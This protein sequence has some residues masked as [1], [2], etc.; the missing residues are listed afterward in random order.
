MTRVTGPTTAQSCWASQARAGRR[1]PGKGALT[2][3]WAQPEPQPQ[4]QRARGA[5]PGPASQ[6]ACSRASRSGWTPARPAAAHTRRVTRADSCS[7][8]LSAPRTP[9]PV[10]LGRC[11]LSVGSPRPHGPRA[12]CGVDVSRG[13]SSCSCVCMWSPMRARP[14]PRPAGAIRP[15]GRPALKTLARPEIR[16]RRRRLRATDIGPTERE[17]L[18]VWLT[19]GRTDRRVCAGDG[20]LAGRRAR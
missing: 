9:P 11:V 3:H 19:G 18:S 4:P 8:G 6:P 10:G 14:G 12:L 13:L 1:D 15:G 2:T 16:T 5:P 7:L 17:S 20:P